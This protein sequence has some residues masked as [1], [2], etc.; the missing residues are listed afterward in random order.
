MRTNWGMRIL[1]I[2]MA[3]AML[4]VETPRAMVA[5]SGGRMVRNI[6]V[7]V[8]DGMGYNQVYATGMYD[9]GTTGSQAFE[10]FPVR[11]SMSTYPVG[12][13]YDPAAAWSRYNYVAT[14]TI[15]DSA[16]AATA[17][18]TGFKSYDGAIGMI[19]ES[20]AYAVPGKHVT[21][22]CEENGMATGVVTTVPVSH[23]TPGGFVAHN[24]SRNNYADI[25]KEML[26]VSAVDVIMGAGHPEFDDNNRS[27]T[28]TDYNSVGWVSTWNGLKAGTL[29]VADADHNGQAD[30]RWTLIESKAQFEDLATTTTPPKR[31][32]GIAQ[33]RQTLQFF[34]YDPARGNS[35]STYA[36][37]APYQVPLNAGVPTLAT[38]TK[39]ALNVLGR[40]PGGFFL[41]VEGG[42]I[43]WCGHNY[44]KG[45]LIEEGSDFFRAIDAVIAWVNAKSSWDATMLVVTADHETGFLWGPGSNPSFAPLVNNGKGK[46]PGMQYGSNWHTNALV[47]FYM[48]GPAPLA[49]V[50]L[51]R[52][53][54]EDSRRGKYIDNTDLGQVLIGLVKGEIALPRTATHQWRGYR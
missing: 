11:L 52:I 40:N 43:D 26:G 1:A 30:D 38:M 3:L 33:V 42:A 32:C 44:Q 7:M 8:G 22:W 27:T 39:G 10:K 54:G 37:D 48:K 21:Q 15:T 12:G 35:L 20:A 53:D 47:P 9:K 51:N 28:S 46:M 24:V 4:G 49:D 14:S 25:A 50:F 23:A 31:V 41:M 36:E 45:R 6:I 2:L 13:S 18:S 34:R 5:S 16:P 19:G 17:M 29:A